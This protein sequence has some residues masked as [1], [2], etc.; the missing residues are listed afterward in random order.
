MFVAEIISEPYVWLQFQD[1]R[2]YEKIYITY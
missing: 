2:K 1:Q